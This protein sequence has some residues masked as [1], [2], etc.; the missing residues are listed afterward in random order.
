[1]KRLFKLLSIALTVAV[2]FSMTAC[3]E[4]PENDNNKD[5]SEQLS[6][7]LINNGTAYR[8][9]KGTVNSGKVVIP[10]THS[11]TRATDDEL[12]VLEI[13]APTDDEPNG[14]FRGTKITSMIIPEGVKAIYAGG[15]S[16][17][18]E[19]TSVTLPESLER[20]GHAAF[21]G[22]KKLTRIDIPGGTIIDE[23][24]FGDCSGLTEV[25][26]GEGITEI[27]AATFNFC[28]SLVSINIPESVTSIGGGA[29]IYCP[30]LTSLI[31]PE[32]LQHIG[33]GAFTDTTKIS[34]ITIPAS[35]TSVGA[36]YGF[37]N[38]S[39]GKGSWA[40]FGWT[41]EQTIYIEGFANEKEADEAWGAGW[42]QRCNAKIVYKGK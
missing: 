14:A 25:T 17:C 35:V 37:S 7:E 28:T 11:R 5:A 38:G 10:A 1:M 32:G 12:P 31:L 18:L 39:D 9:R 16:D 8:V 27:K 21:W 2:M 29:F 23:S 41:S 26:I 19:L 4:D 15:L 33:V 22:S 36:G 34:E 40:F 30:S 6:F 42:R 3:E 20:I 13:G 24:A